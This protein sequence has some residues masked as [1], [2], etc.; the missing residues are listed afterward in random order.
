MLGFVE[1][2]GRLPRRLGRLTILSGVE[3]LKGDDGIPGLVI[4]DFAFTIQDC[5]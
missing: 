2:A 1:R 3:G 4:Y 5:G